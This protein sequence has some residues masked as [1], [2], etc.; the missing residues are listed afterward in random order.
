MEEIVRGWARAELRRWAT[1]GFTGK[2]LAQ[3]HVEINDNFQSVFLFDISSTGVVARTKNGLYVSGQPRGSTHGF[4]RRV[5]L[6]L[7]FFNRLLPSLVQKPFTV[8]VDVEDLCSDWTT[9]PVFSFQKASEFTNI[10]LPDVDF[11][12]E[13]FYEAESAYGLSED[14]GYSE[15][16][17]NAV[18]AGS[19]TGAG[20][21]TAEKLD[22]NEVPRVRAARFFKDDPRVHFSIPN[23]VQCQNQTI[24]QRLRDEKLGT[25]RWSWHDQLKYRFLISMDGNGATCSRIYIALKSNSIL[26]KYQSPHLL[27][28]FRGLQPDVHYVDIARDTEVIE[29]VEV[30]LLHRD[31]HRPIAAA[32]TEFATNFLSRPAVELY[33]KELFRLYSQIIVGA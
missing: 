13:D 4:V 12:A 32:A 8:A 22:R 17:A 9:T 30:E 31:Y 19:S 11:L 16:V 10:L 25:D 28:Y 18:F 33:T 29:A 2:D 24:E 3:R 14:R 27:Y 5:E 15:K 7:D 26:L 20:T 6:Y 1:Y 21:I 23:L